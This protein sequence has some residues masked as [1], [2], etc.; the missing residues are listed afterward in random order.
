MSAAPKPHPYVAPSP[1]AR[2]KDGAALGID[3]E[4]VVNTTLI[5]TEGMRA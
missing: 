1:I 3:W 2:D 4:T 5:K